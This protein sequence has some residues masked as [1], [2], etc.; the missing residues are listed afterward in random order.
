MYDS[1]LVR[2]DSL[3]NVIKDGK[4]IGFKFGV[5][6]ADYRGNFLSLINGFYVAVDG[7]EYGT[8]L[9]SFEINGKP[10][11]PVS[12]LRNYPWEHWNMQDEAF[13][14]IAKEGGLSP[15]KH[16]IEY[17]QST[18]GQYGYGLHDEE[19]VNNPPDIK[20]RSVGGKTFNICKFEC[21]LK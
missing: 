11:R 16:I 14:H 8:E 13:L 10:P 4:V 3:E 9:Q 18:L 2:S 17:K 1:F 5:R 19:Y 6:I 21:I 7:V 20:G 15:G 12:E